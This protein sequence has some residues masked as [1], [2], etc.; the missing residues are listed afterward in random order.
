MPAI[1]LQRYHRD[2]L[3]VDPL[4][5]KTFDSG[6]TAFTLQEIYTAAQ[7]Y[8]CAS[9]FIKLLYTHSLILK[10]LLKQN[11]YTFPKVLAFLYEISQREKS[12]GEREERKECLNMPIIYT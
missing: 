8:A 9:A 2:G 4:H 12:S 5:T 11:F 7:G 10:S 3:V 6:L 1:I